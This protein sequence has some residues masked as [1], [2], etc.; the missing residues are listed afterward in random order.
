MIT[1]NENIDDMQVSALLH[2]KSNIID[3]VLYILNF[4]ATESTIYNCDRY[5][6]LL[7]KCVY[8][9]RQ[10]S[11]CLPGDGRSRSG[12]SLYCTTFS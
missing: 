8:S 5:F 3:L 2:T 1:I 10:Q 11:T 12:K 6:G 4:T 9:Y 7:N